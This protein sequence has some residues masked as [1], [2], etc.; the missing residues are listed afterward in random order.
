MIQELPVAENDLQKYLLGRKSTQSYSKVLFE[1]LFD[2]NPLENKK[3]LE[4]MVSGWARKSPAAE[5]D[6]Q[7]SSQVRKSTQ[8]DKKITFKFFFRSKSFEKQGSSGS[9][10]LGWS[11]SWGWTP[12]IFLSSLNDSLDQDA[13]IDIYMSMSILKFIIFSCNILLRSKWP[14]LAI[15]GVPMADGPGGPFLDFLNVPIDRARKINLVR[16]SSFFDRISITLKFF[17]F[18]GRLR[19]F[20]PQRPF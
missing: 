3:V 5:D 14:H 2:Q 17:M 19:S 7:N 18:L 6:F 8:E 1:F 16:Y 13:S 10:T 11:R 12:K 9:C 20:W 15:K 4:I